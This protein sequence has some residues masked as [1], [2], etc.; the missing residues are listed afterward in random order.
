M[1]TFQMRGRRSHGHLPPSR[2]P[3]AVGAAQEQ[4]AGFVRNQVVMTAEQAT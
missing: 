1:R 3:A 4:S 2:F